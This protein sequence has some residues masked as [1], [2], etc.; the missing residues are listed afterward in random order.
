MKN[1][2][3]VHGWADKSEFDDLSARTPSNNHWL[4]WLTKQLMVR[5]IHTVALEMPT[6]YYPEY[7]L[8]KKELERFEI[9]QNTILV[10]H[11]CGGGFIIRWLSENPNISIKKIVLVAPWIGFEPKADFD[12]TFFE[13]EIDQNIS[14]RVKDLVMLSSTDDK[15]GVKK[16]EEVLKN[17]LHGLRYVEFQNKGHFTLKS[18]GSEEFPELLEE[19]VR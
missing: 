13:F 8:W 16:S 9:D 15:P 7:H 14:K 6:S 18:L 11:S 19:I 3:L 4:P 1:A 10:G 12:K 2:F 17:K 5:G